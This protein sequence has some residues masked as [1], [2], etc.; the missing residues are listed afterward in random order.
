[1]TH[2][3]NDIDDFMHEDVA[4]MYIQ[5]ENISEDRN[6]YSIHHKSILI[7]SQLKNAS[8][9]FY[10]HL[11]DYFIYISFLVA[12][13]SDA[14]RIAK[15]DPTQNM[16]R[17]DCTLS[18]SSI[19]EMTGIPR[20]TVRRRLKQLVKDGKLEIINGKFS[21]SFSENE[22]RDYLEHRN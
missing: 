13:A 22:I 4:H 20:E 19:S 7:F 3:I 8:V 6:L 18:P 14:L 9:K 10:G 5:N 21:A 12:A 17:I 15:V 1:M 16:S 2:A 11:D